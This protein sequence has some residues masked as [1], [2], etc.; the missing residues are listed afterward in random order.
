MKTQVKTHVMIP[1]LLLALALFPSVASAVKVADITRISGQQNN[2]LQGWGLVVG[3][4]GTGDGGDYAPAMRP[5]REWLTQFNDPVTMQELSKSANVALVMITCTL[6]KDGMR[7]GDRFDVTVQSIGAASSLRGGVLLN[8]PLYSDPKDKWWG[9]AQGTVTIEDPA[10]PG[11]GIIKQGFQGEYNLRQPYVTDNKFFTLIIDDAQASWGTA[12]YM[13]KAINDFERTSD[14]KSVAVA[15]V[16]D[17]RCVEVTIPEAERAHPDNFIA[18]VLDIQLTQMPQEARVTINTRTNT[19]V[20]SGDVEISPV[21]ISFKGLTVTTITPKP[22]ASPK[23]P[24]VSTQTFVP[25]ETGRPEGPS[26]KLQDLVSALEQLKVPTEDRIKIIL[27]MH[28]Q[29]KIRAKLYIDGVMP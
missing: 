27:E 7:K 3:L 2:I 24:Q 9:F 11:A 17:P 6:P 8:V 10:T 25:I 5:L 26:P 29:G 21:V 14:D 19:L 20:V 4:K 12:N 18:G 1:V 13:A 22:V 16:R 15:V 28:R 23:V